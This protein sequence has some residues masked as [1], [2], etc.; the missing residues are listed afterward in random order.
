MPVPA[1]RAVFFDLFETLITEFADGKRKVP[2][3]NIN[4][5][6]FFQIPAEQFEQAWKERLRRR[7]TGQFPDYPSVLRD[8]ASAA[9]R[10]IDEERIE[11]LY[12][13]R[14]N[15]KAIV[16]EDIDENVIHM[17]KQ[18]RQKG[19][20]LGL[21][22]N[23]AEEEVRA[24]PACRLAPYFDAVILSCEVGVAKPDEEIYKLACQ[25]LNVT[26]QE[27]LFVG[28]GGSNELDGASRAGMAA[29]HAAWFVP[30]WISEKFAQYPKLTAPADILGQWIDE[31]G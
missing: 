11:A 21:I 5:A 30:P 26:P 24:W 25:R 3:S 7:M 4:G 31:A 1:I 28:D 29:L 16:F 2:R 27:S 17:L 6:A 12:Q 22:S 15:S 23:C 9:G 10:T 13:E 8:I 19:I 20:R 18:L 14:L